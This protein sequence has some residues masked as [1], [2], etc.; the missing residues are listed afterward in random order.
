VQARGALYDRYAAHVERVLLRVLGPDD[1]IADLMQEVFLAAIEGIDGLAEPARLRAWLSG[2]AVFK[3]RACIRRRR[4]RRWLWFMAP[5]ELPERGVEPAPHELPADERIAFALRLIDGMEL[6]EVAE[7]CGV[8]LAT[9]KRRL[10]RARDEF[11]ERALTE[12]A[13]TDWVEGGSSWDRT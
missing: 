11:R 9:V 3:A 13:L 7:A 8:S 5:E 10:A 2:I 6:T 12:P 1:E 4:R